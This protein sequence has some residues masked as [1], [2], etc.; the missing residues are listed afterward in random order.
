MS[1]AAACG[2]SHAQTFPARE[3]GVW[4]VQVVTRGEGARREGA[5][6]DER[7]ASLPPDKRAQVEAL[8]KSRGVGQAG[9]A[10]TMTMRFC[11][12]PQDVAGDAAG[13]FY[14][15][16]ERGVTCEHRT[17][18]RSASELRFTASCTRNG[19]LREMSGRVYDVTPTTYSAEYDTT[20]DRGAVTVRQRARWLYADCSKLK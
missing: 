4:E 20:T 17:V 1:L 12:A 13:G 2:A 15:R 18:S 9:D 16:S 8:M 6:L 5:S 14:P 11:L 19:K 7:L 3:P 10:T